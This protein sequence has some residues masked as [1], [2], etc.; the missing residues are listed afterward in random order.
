MMLTG[1]LQWMGMEG[2]FWTLKSEGKTY[3]LHADRKL[4]EGL[5]SGQRVEVNGKVRTDMACFHM[6]GI[7][8]EL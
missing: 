7:I 2:G 4:F 6:C 3:G 5:K 8:F 1:E